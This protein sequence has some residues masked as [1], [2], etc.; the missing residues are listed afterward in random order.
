[1]FRR[2]NIARG[3]LAMVPI[4]AALL[5]LASPAHA[6]APSGSADTLAVEQRSDGDNNINIG[7]N[8]GQVTINQ[9]DP[10][11]LAA[12]AKVFADQ[13]SATAEARAKA[14]ARAAELAVKL[15]FTTSAVSEFFRILGVGDQHRTSVGLDLA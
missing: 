1:M 10:A 3:S 6:A 4:A 15:G 5:T 7:V 9:Q 14:E 13:M 2:L 11:V 8:N 12:M